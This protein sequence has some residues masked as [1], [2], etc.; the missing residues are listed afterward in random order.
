MDVP[1]S[2]VSGDSALFPYSKPLSCPLFFIDMVSLS[3]GSRFIYLRPI[4]VPS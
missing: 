4:S 2:Y 1:V 3:A